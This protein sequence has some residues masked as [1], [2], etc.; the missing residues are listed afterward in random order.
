VAF[1]FPWNLVP[2]LGYY[3]NKLFQIFL[4]F[5]MLKVLLREVERYRDMV[6]DAPRALKLE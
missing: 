2:I 4:T 3:C 6:P 5:V 1:L